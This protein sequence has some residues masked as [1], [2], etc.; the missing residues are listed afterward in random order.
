MVE[1]RAS[2]EGSINGNFSLGLHDEADSRYPLSNEKL[3]QSCRVK[4]EGA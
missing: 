3:E 1:I 2:K 4:T